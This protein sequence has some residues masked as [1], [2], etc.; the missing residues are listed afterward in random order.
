MSSVQRK[1]TANRSRHALPDALR[2]LAMVSVLVVNGIGYAV[3]PWGPALGLR[4]PADS[5]WA[6]VTQGFVA[7]LLQGKGLAMLAFVFGMALWLSASGRVRTEALQRGVVR[8]RRLLRLGMLHGV[9]VYFGDILTL[10]AL[11]GRRLLGRLHLPWRRFRQHLRRALVWALLAKLVLVSIILAF[12]ERPIDPGD[13]TLSTV[14]GGWEFFKLNASSYVIAQVVVIILAGPV[15]YL[16]MACGVAAARLR[17]LTH[18]RWRP[19]LK[20]GLLRSA[21][22]LLALTF[23]YGWGMAVT[24]PTNALRPWI[25]ALGDLVAIPVAFIYIAALA[26]VTNGGSA[27]WCGW[28]VPLGQRTLTLYVAH[29]LICLVVL[30]GAGFALSLTTT[31]IVAC[32]LGLWLLALAAAALSRNRRWPLEAWISRR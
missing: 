26:L 15:M 14:R 25:D 32:C 27:R 6:S 17:L 28:L 23:A 30:S 13:S 1:T 22:P 4:T 18:R 5:T 10:Y 29:G 20:R 2:A 12:P 11:V 3:A 16:C 19:D 8:N 9:F 7:A 21:P 31:Q 24:E